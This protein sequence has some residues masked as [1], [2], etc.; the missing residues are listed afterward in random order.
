ME[1]WEKGDELFWENTNVKQVQSYIDN[2]GDINARLG[3]GWSVLHGA[4]KY[5]HDPEV[6]LFLVSMGADVNFRCRNGQTS[7]HLAIE[8]ERSI[9]IIM[10]L[11]EKKAKLNVRNRDGK[12]PLHLAAMI[13]NKEAPEIIMALIENGADGTLRDSEGNIPFNYAE[14]NKKIIDTEF[15]IL[16]DAY[17]ELHESSWALREKY[18]PASNED[19]NKEI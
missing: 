13:P 6:I 16:T 18:I 10:A 5:C 12:T 1:K 8:R 3:C 14:K 2:M 19:P 7:L 4:M 17:W 15:Q 11:L 9:K